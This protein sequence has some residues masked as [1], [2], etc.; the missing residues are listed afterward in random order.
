MLQVCVCL[1]VAAAFATDRRAHLVC[2]S[3]DGCLVLS[4]RHGRLRT[5]G[6]YE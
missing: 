5:S 3:Q 4:D 6:A 2:V 1:R